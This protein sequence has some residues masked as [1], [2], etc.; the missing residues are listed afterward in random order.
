MTPSESDLSEVPDQQPKTILPIHSSTNNTPDDDNEDAEDSALSD[1]NDPSM[2]SDDGDFEMDS[3]IPAEH[4]ALETR[5]SSEES[6][7]PPKRKAGIEDDEDI[8]NNPELYGIR[9]SVRISS[10]CSTNSC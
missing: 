10:P 4:G 1:N 3:P 2:G 8:M 9:R 5:S 7:R 6:R